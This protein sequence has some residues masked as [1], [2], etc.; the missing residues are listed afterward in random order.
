MNAVIFEASLPR[1]R[2]LNLNL[3]TWMIDGGYV[4]GPI[5]GGLVLAGEEK[6]YGLLYGL[7]AAMILAAAAVL[8]V[9]R[10]IPAPAET[11]EG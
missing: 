8:R 5:L 2:G 10:A 11:P 4:I 1:Y 3:S 7:C 9:A 6:R